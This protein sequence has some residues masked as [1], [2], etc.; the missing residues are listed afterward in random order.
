MPMPIK[1]AKEFHWEMAHRLPLHK[2]GC[3]N[4]HGH[5]YRLWI[6]LEGSTTDQGMVMDYADLKKIAKP[7]VDELDHCFICSSDDEIMQEFLKRQ[8]FKTVYVDFPTTAE[9][10]AKYFLE[11]LKLQLSHVRSIRRLKI[12]VCETASSYAEIECELPS[13]E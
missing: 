3:E 13:H 8:P 5:S 4:L 12:R 2:G 9:N 7:M 11:R 6:E 1:I 10:L